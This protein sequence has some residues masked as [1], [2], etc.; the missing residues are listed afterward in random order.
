MFGRTIGGALGVAVFGS[1]ANSTLVGWLRNPPAAIAA[2]LPHGANAAALI[3]GGSSGIHDRAASS[4][5]REGL[6][7]AVHHVFVALVVIAVA[8]AFAVAAIPRRVVALT[9]DKP[10][11]PRDSVPTNSPAARE[12]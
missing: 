9:F 6:Y 11:M 5:V 8:L 7:L 10:K 1:I 3:L 2:H 12:R 4:F